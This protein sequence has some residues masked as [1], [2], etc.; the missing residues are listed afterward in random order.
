MD[1][2]EGIKGA[3]SSLGEYQDLK[4]KYAKHTGLCSQI[5]ALY[6]QRLLEKV[7]KVEQDCVM[8]PVDSDKKTKQVMKE[9]MALMEDGDLEYFLLI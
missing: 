1:K 7:S 9:F 2:I 3:V 4:A 5:M 6:N 8:T